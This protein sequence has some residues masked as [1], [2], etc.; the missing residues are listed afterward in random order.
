MNLMNFSLERV[1]LG[2]SVFSSATEE[3]VKP[4]TEITASQTCHIWYR[5]VSIR[6]KFEI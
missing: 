1:S 3:L 4:E 5:T 6:Q 2:F